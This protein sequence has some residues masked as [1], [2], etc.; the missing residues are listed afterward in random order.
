MAK[1]KKGGSAAKKRSS[2]ADSSDD[3]QQQLNAKLSE[4]QVADDVAEADEDEAEVSDVAP[5]AKSGG[6]AG[7]LLDE[8][9][10]E[11]DESEEDDDEAPVVA[12]GGG[13]ADLLDMD[14]DDAEDQQETA[15]EPEPDRKQESEDD[16]FDVPRPAAKGKNKKQQKKQQKAGKGGKKASA[17]AAEDQDDLDDILAE[18]EPAKPAAP[19][20][21]GKGK[22]KKGGKKGSAAAAA[23]EDDEDL[24]DILA[25]LE[26]AKP[27]PA[28][29]AA[30][31]PAAAAQGGKGKKGKGKKGGKAGKEEPAAGADDLDTIMAELDAPKKPVAAAAAAAPQEEE[32]VDGD[33]EEDLEA[34]DQKL[35]KAQLK[36]LRKRQQ[37]QA[38]KDDPEAQKKKERERQK[39]L[40]KERADKERQAKE[41]AAAAAKQPKGIAALKAR[42]QKQRE[43]EEA[44]QR[45]LEELRRQEE[46]EERRLIEEA[47]VKEELRQQKIRERQARQEQLRRENQNMSKKQRAAQAKA[48]ADLEAMKRAGGYVAE[49][50]GESTSAKKDSK[51]KDKDKKKT[52]QKKKGPGLTREE[53]RR[54]AIHAEAQRAIQEAERRAQEE[55]ARLE[56][57][58]K[59][60]RQQVLDGT[61]AAAD[62]A[63]AGSDSDSDSDSDDASDWDA[64]DKPS[65]GAA[66]AAADDFG[67]NWEDLMSTD[68]EA[69]GDNAG[70]DGDD[71]APE[72][73]EMVDSDEERQKDEARQKKELE[74]QRRRELRAQREKEIAARKTKLIKEE[75]EREQ[76]ERA[77]RELQESTVKLQGQFAGDFM[78]SSSVDKDGE[79]HELRS[80]ICCILGHV[81]TG[82]TRLCDKLRSSK[83][84][85][86][87][88]GGITQQIGATYF[89]QSA[90]REKA[91]GVDP[92]LKIDIPGLLLIDTPGHAS[93]TNLRSRGSDLC[94]IA[95]LVV[96]ITAGL[97]VQTLESL[98]LLRDRRTP[99]VVAMNKIDRCYGWNATPW[100][101]TQQTLAKQPRHTQQE[102]ERRSNDLVVQLAEQ[103][104]SAQ[105]YWNNND[106]RRVVN[107]VPTSAMTGEGIPDLLNLI[108]KLTQTRMSKRIHLNLHKL[109][110]TVLEVKKVQG[111]G[112]TI[113][114]ILVNGV[115]HEG[116]TIVLCGGVHGAI[117]T[118]IR[119]LLTP[120]P[121]HEIRVKGEYIQHKQVKAAMGIKI[122]AHGLENAVAGSSLFVLG[123][124]DD[125]ED[126]KDQVQN[127]YGGV[128]SRISS[129]GEGVFVQASTLGSLEALLDFLKDMKIPVAGISMGDIQK[130]DVL[131]AAVMR[132]RRPEYACILGF[133]VKVAGDAQEQAEQHQVRLFTADVIYH[134]FDMCTEYMTEMRDQK[135]AAVK[136]I[137]VFPA[138]LRILP[139]CIFRDRDPLVLGC[140]VEAGFLRTGTPVCV[141]RGGE[142][143]KLGVVDSLQVDK[144]DVLEVKKGKEVCIRIA[145]PLNAR[146][147]HPHYG[148]HFDKDNLIMSE[149]S[150]ASI[151]ALKDNFR[152]DLTKEDWLT[153]VKI[154]KALSIA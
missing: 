66:A 32:D 122:T 13:F 80:P 115:L 107:I 75:K 154:K 97:Q 141:V 88:A 43:E 152:D 110:C 12:R 149:L 109:E 38:L 86:R 92:D 81:D 130:K 119:S 128:L 47:R 72:S 127:D 108:V 137:I 5:R 51:D 145:P 11:A 82:K 73:W 148:R 8:D 151:D 35:T 132:E 60:A 116:D 33:D 22:G 129:D 79:T 30:A 121:M 124:K 89:P 41:A 125:V 96:D 44:L 133:D 144:K 57:L 46:E 63:A 28:S 70:D 98:R 85:E 65:A 59:L 71:S 19:T 74:R 140:I 42:L 29:A 123:P 54:A 112:T 113:D 24:D 1:K 64:E 87:E 58:E 99:F 3:E 126:L 34:G 61:A 45:E 131:R 136:E 118:Q 117:V 49:A 147:R 7:L 2:A 91:A 143:L 18:L 25:D 10:D 4:L 48:R 142:T 37:A 100:A 120:Q 36:R 68:E 138:I 76:R 93:F 9:E 78:G 20:K 84:G 95:I 104:L 94:D 150:R 77:A 56:E 53:V 50:A 40:E 102:F 153:V 106:P 26:P 21:A 39:Q 69:G 55:A 15:A 16:E 134:L 17:G 83:V 135:R 27:A 52:F 111:L 101:P 67:E 114:V 14:D 146:V 103:G 23:V 6:F 90:L 62:A 31:A 139:E 105:L